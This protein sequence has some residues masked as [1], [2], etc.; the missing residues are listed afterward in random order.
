MPTAIP[1]YLL[2]CYFDVSDVSFALLAV[3]SKEIKYFNF[4]YTYSE[5]A[6][7]NQINEADFNKAVIE[8]VL[9]D[10]KIKISDVEVLVMGLLVEPPVSIETKL[11][12]KFTSVVSEIPNIY[13]FIVN[14]FTVMTR[15]H[16]LSY[17]D[18]EYKS[19]K[20]ID[21]TEFDDLANLSVYPQLVPV[22]IPT[23]TV[24]DKGL[25]QKAGGVSLEYSSGQT[26]TFSGSR[27]SRNPLQEYLDWILALDL[28]RNP[29]F[30]RLLIDKKNAVP[31]CALISKYNPE[32]NLDP[33]SDTEALGTLVNSPGDTEC[34]LSSDLGTSQFFEVK[35]DAFY[36]VPAGRDSK[37]SL[38]LKSHSLGNQGK[39]IQGGRA[40]LIVK[41]LD[42]SVSL[43]NNIKVFN[44][45]VNQ[46]S[47]CIRRY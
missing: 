31:L 35:K 4:P 40:G 42:S 10:N 44:G 29:G 47:L 2:A 26:L 34:L 45:S 39:V 33:E 27:F 30:Y 16:I 3:D 13:P 20:S 28:V 19:Q 5:Q 6:F 37:I 14:E 17:Q 21:P 41:T 46:L 36:T 25:S 22:D 12:T 11:S 24:L 15:D 9:K 18:R 38:S 32:I 43:Y 23:I 8:S 7:S 1:R